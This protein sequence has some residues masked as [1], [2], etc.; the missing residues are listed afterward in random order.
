MEDHTELKNASSYIKMI[1]E[2]I[3]HPSIHAT[4]IISILNKTVGNQIHASY[5]DRPKPETLEKK[6][7]WKT[8]N[9][10]TRAYIL[11]KWIRHWTTV[12]I[13]M[14]HRIYTCL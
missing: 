1:I 10:K 2:I 14:G 7:H 4:L 9:T 3:N 11:R 5:L 6:V 12:K 8:E 13:I